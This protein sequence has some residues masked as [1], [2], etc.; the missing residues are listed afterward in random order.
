MVQSDK[1]EVIGMLYPKIYFPATPNPDIPTLTS[2]RPNNSIYDL[3]IMRE[4]SRA[5]AVL[6]P[7]TA[8]TLN[9][10][11]NPMIAKNTMMRAVTELY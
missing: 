2:D 3:H 10:T 4:L 9:S 5:I 7:T 11:H 6:L 1:L 8:T